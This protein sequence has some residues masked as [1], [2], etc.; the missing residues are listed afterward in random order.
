MR[1]PR[2]RSSSRRA[3]ASRIAA[4]NASALS[5]S[6]RTAASPHA[7]SSDGCDDATTGAPDAI[8]SVIGIPKP[9]KRDG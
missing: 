4:A 7:S 3:S 8:A 6:A 5:G 2:A 1:K 9:S